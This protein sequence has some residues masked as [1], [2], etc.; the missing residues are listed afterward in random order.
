MWSEENDVQWALRHIGTRW[1]GVAYSILTYSRI[2]YRL[3]FGRLGGSRFLLHLC[4]SVSD[5]AVVDSPEEH[6]SHILLVG[7]EDHVSR[8]AVIG[9]HAGQR[10]VNARAIQTSLAN[11][12]E[13]C[14]HGVVCQRCKLLGL[15][16]K[17][18]IETLVEVEP[19]RIV[20]GWIVGKPVDD[21]LPGQHQ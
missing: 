4:D 16:V 5:L 7:I 2:R 10:I 9:T 21:P 14:I 3:R 20:A 11:G 8:Y 15:L 17:L 12:V 6:R 1:A 13:Q 18:R 19:A